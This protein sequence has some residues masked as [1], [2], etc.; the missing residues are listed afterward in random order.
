MRDD[1]KSSC[2]VD[3]CCLSLML[4]SQCIL[5]RTI[6]QKAYLLPSKMVLCST[7]LCTSFARLNFIILIVLTIKYD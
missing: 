4:I 1:N 5:S 6:P 7:V 2:L 3:C